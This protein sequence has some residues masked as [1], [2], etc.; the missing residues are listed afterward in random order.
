MPVTRELRVIGGEPERDPGGEK[1]P[2][3][4]SAKFASNDV[5][6]H[7]VVSECVCCF[8]VDDSSKSG[9]TTTGTAGEL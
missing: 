6:K 1:I 9:E 5:A 4:A 2:S 8:V 3:P 7:V